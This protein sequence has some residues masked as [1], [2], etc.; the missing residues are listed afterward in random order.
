MVRDQEAP[1]V[2][3]TEADPGWPERFE[4][5]RARLEP[6]L[7]GVEIHHV[8][9]T[10][11][12][13]LAAKPIIDLMALVGDLDAHLK[14]LLGPAGGYCLPAA[15]NEDL[16]DR[17]YLTRPTEAE[18]TH[19]LH[20]VS[21]RETL[22][23]YLTFRD[24]LRASADLRAEYEALKRDLAVRFEHDREGYTAAKAPFVFRVLGRRPE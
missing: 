10:A 14:V 1:R 24:A 22:E 15:A 6:L 18:R 11:V 8:G 12:P 16:D 13:G 4:A 2:E 3:V 5:E 7:P 23:R 17:R 19:N 9:S 20:L 21:R